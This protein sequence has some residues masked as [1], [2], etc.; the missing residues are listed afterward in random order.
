MLR[1][2]VIGTGAVGGFYGIRLAEA[3]ADVQFMFRRDAH[4][5]RERG[6]LLTSPLGDVQLTEATVRGSWSELQPCDVL[7]VAVKATSNAEVRQQLAEHVDRVLAP[8]GAILL[9]QNGIG[10]EADYARFG[11]PVLGGLAFLGAKRTGP[12]TVAHLDFGALTLAAHT[13]G[14]QPAGSTPMMRSVAED[15]SAARVDT[16]LDDDLVAARWRKLMWNVPFNPLSVILDATTDEIM[17]DESAVGLVRRVMQEVASAAAA[18]DRPIPAEFVDGLLAVT[19]HMA[20]YATS[21][22]LDADA[23]R[24]MEVDVLLAEPL[25]RARRAG[26]DMPSVQVL[27][28][29]L[30]FLDRRNATRGQGRSR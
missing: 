21:M 16:V 30:A 10:V 3:G 4:M 8:R 18:E 1:Y 28:D 19:A 15:L 29:Q 24:P 2:A 14:E 27:L 5:V 26:V 11:V 20:P 6:L 13:H 25:R 23:G 22:K 17:A 7:L 12:G 9:I